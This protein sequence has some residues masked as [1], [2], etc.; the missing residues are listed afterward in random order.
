MSNAMD[1]TNSNFETEVIKSPLPVLVDFWAPWCGPCLMMGPVLDEIAAQNEGKL[2]IVKVNTDLPENQELAFK[3]Q[4]NS[5]PNMKVF[6]GGT[7][8]KELI[9][10]RPKE[11]MMADLKEVLE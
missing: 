6:K 2:K 3:Y 8:V 9:G 7:L 5:I 1:V 11:M 10:F 4:V